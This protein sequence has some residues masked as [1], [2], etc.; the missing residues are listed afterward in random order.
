MNRIQAGP[1]IMVLTI[2]GLLTTGCELNLLRHSEADFIRGA[3]RADE[4]FIKDQQEQALKDQQRQAKK[5]EEAKKEQTTPPL[6]PTAPQP[7]ERK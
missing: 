2:A 7:G 4:A 3:Q 5:A 1:V 6:T